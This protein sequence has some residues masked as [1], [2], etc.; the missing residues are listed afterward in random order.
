MSHW[1]ESCAAPRIEEMVGARPAVET[2]HQAVLLQDTI[3]F[4]HRGFEPVIIPVILE[5]AARTVAII[6]QIR[7]VG[8]DEIDALGGHLLHDLDAIALDDA[9][10]NLCLKVHR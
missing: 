4:G 3:C 1:P 2:Y 6:Y 7:R 8:E 9:V 10:G 5:S